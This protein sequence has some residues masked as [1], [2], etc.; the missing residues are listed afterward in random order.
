MPFKTAKTMQT[1]RVAHILG[2][3]LGSASTSRY[4][5]TIKTNS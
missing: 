1:V 2:S 5:G 3:K 4:M